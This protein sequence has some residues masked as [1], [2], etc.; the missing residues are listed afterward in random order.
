MC[1]GLGW[2]GLGLIFVYDDGG[3]IIL[4]GGI[5]DSYRI[6]W[7]AVMNGRCLVSRQALHIG[8]VQDSHQVVGVIAVESLCYCVCFF[9]YFLIICSRWSYNEKIRGPLSA[10]LSCT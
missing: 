8:R 5:L 4:H 7:E 2:V 3:I 10:R 1:H 9:D 6:S